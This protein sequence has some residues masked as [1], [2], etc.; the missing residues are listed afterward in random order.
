MNF[1]KAI[2]LFVLI[3]NLFPVKN[4][5][6]GAKDSIV[7][8][9]MAVV[10]YA[11]QFPEG[12]LK[13]R[14]GYNNSMGL[15]LLNKTT[16]NWIFGVDYTYTFSGQKQVKN[17]NDLFDSIA[18]A[19]GNI[20]DRN[21]EYVSLKVYERGWTSSLKFGKL[22]PVIGPNKNSGF[23]IIGSIGFMQHKIKIIDTY[24]RAPQLSQAYRKGYDRLTSGLM[25]S[26]FVGYIFLSTNRLVNI[27]GGFEI[28]EGFTKSRRSFNFDTEMRDTKNYFDIYYGPRIGVILPLY[29]RL[30]NDFYYN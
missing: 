24:N 3:L 14:F 20:L 15:H 19:D 10:S 7:N 18:T 11:F 9:P 2:I 21:G 26:Q 13:E 27:Y 17:V 25:L 29:K 23:C 28:M 30:P 4:L 22:F 8:A 16:K 12:D 5:I 6:A 1:K